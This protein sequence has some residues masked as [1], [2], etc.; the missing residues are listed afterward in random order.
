M[1][2]EKRIAKELAEAFIMM[3]RNQDRATIEFVI[4]QPAKTTNDFLG[5]HPTFW[6]NETF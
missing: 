2:T 4:R 5:K 1:T 6:A 3:G